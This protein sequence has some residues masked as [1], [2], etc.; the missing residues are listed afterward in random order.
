MKRPHLLHAQI[1]QDGIYHKDIECPYDP[2]DWSDERECKLWAGEDP[3]K[4]YLL[5]CC[6][7]DWVDNLTWDELIDGEWKDPQFPLAVQV[8]A[9]GDEF[10]LEPFKEES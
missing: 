5:G 7:T 3:E 9:N 6:A 1:S 10:W 4:G 8:H 2:A